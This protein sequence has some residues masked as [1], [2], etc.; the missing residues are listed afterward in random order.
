M[1]WPKLKILKETLTEN[2]VPFWGQNDPLLC[3][4]A[5]PE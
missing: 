4:L 5:L 2:S 1:S 3:T